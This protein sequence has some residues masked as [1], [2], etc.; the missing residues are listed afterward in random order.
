MN[1]TVDF[2]QFSKQSKKGILV[3]YLKLLYK[4]LKA[5]WVLLFLFIQRFSKF[6]ENTLFYI[7]LGVGCL[8]FIFLIRAYLIYKNFQFKVD[9]GHFI[10]KQGILKKTNTSISFDRIQNINFKQNIIQQLINVHE[11]N[12]E[13]AGSSK[14]E[15]S[16]KALSFKDA[17][18]LKKELTT[19]SKEVKI[20]NEISKPFIKINFIELLKVSLTENH[21]KSLL[22]FL[23]LLLT[24]Y[25]QVKDIFIGFNNEGFLDNAIENST[26]SIGKSYFLLIFLLVLLIIVSLL[27]SV[28][29]VFLIHFDLK[30]FI[31]NKSFT[32]QQGL[33]NKK[34]VLLKNKKIQSITISTNPIKQKLGLSYVTFMQAVSGNVSKKNNKLIKIV[35]CKSFQIEK[36]KNLLY[37][38]KDLEFSEKQQS[39]VFYKKRL[40]FR[41]FLFIT[42]L[43]LALYLLFW[44]LNLLFLNLLLIPSSYF[45]IKIVYK[46]RF[47]KL[48]SSLLQVGSGAFETHLTFL[49]FFKI[50]N[51]KIKQ[52]FF[53]KRYQV[54]DVVF[55]TASG[56]I[57]IPC[58]NEKIAIQIHNYTLYKVES[59]VK[60]WM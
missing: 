24:L 43:N 15:I 51:I 3:I 47:Y 34:S 27:V 12:I 19:K 37:K 50:Q 9:N 18:V 53:Q 10:L 40:F 46:K 11:V 30:V 5:F 42:I 13:T 58:I 35:G 33:L 6:S 28:T 20:V 2:S 29:K 45:W 7:Y 31:K 23:A 16:I 39:D 26:N 41:S 38:E 4:L 25:Q 60:S 55:Q 48:S 21:L 17:E 36:I 54:A 14:T 57:K 32:I 49:P 22:L 59:S 1:N 44:D 52:T 56:K 8:L